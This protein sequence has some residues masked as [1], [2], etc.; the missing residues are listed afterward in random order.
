MTDKQKRILLSLDAVDDKAID[1]ARPKERK[2]PT[3]KI[4]SIAASLIVTVGLVVG[5]VLLGGGAPPVAERPF[6]DVPRPQGSL[7]A[8]ME[9]YLQ[10]DYGSS[11]DFGSDDGAM[12]DQFPEV[13][14]PGDS[15]NNENSGENY[16][17]SYVE[18][19]DNQIAGIVEGDL[20]K[21]TDKYIFRYREGTLCIYSIKGEDSV[22]ISHTGIDPDA[23]KNKADMFLSGDGN[24]VTV[25]YQKILRDS[26]DSF[27]YSGRYVTTV[28]SIDVTDVYNPRIS[29]TIEISG[30][31]KAVRRIGEKIYVATSVGFDKNDIDIDDAA[32]YVP[33]I[34]GDVRHTCEL[35]RVFYPNEITCAVYNYVT[36]FNESD[37]S[38]SSEYAILSSIPSYNSSI[39][40]SDNHIVISSQISRKI[41]E[42]DGY[43]ITEAYSRIDLI[44][45]SGDTL[46]YRGSLE[47]KGRAE[48]GQYSFDEQDGYL[49]I[50]TSTRK[51]KRY[52]SM[53]VSA[54]LYVYDL[55][56][57]KSVASVENFAPEG[58]SATAVRFEGDKLYVCTAETS[59]FSDPVFFFDLSDYDNITQVNT[60]Y[61]EGFSTSLIDIGGGY[62]VGIG[63]ESRTHIKIEVYK[64][65]GGSV[66]SVAEYIC[67]GNYDSDYHSYLIDRENN[68]LG[69]SLTYIKDDYSVSYGHGYFLWHFDENT[70]S[71]SLVTE[72]SSATEHTLFNYA[73]A[74]VRDGYLY[75]TSANNYTPLVVKRV[76]IK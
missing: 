51:W 76:E 21:T 50:V 26:D 5:A 47:V 64:R 67:R 16:K 45:F 70:E 62:L 65:D 53:E 56:T 7:A 69:L 4:I 12:D 11:G 54:S 38:L 42:Q 24:T 14:A 20:Y 39:Y 8:V 22:Y 55:S 46:R 27:I 25:I 29:K 33:G 74:F 9:K 35:E 28:C 1:Q 43:P 15:G 57:M 17:G 32:T 34:S 3:A 41:D 36:V 40:F 63:R 13:E 44:D 59:K 6:P 30:L 71:L 23:P 52:W 73:R 19:T 31:N 66:V 75:L 60:G 68:L 61:I 58:E 37:L 48:S 72:I 49:R 18:V 10:S 2:N